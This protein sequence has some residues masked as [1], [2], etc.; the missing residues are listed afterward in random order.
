MNVQY[1]TVTTV[2][3]PLLLLPAL[4]TPRPSKVISHSLYESHLRSAHWI[5]T[6][7]CILSCLKYLRSASNFSNVLVILSI[8]TSCSCCS[9][10]KEKWR[11]QGNQDIFVWITIK[12]FVVFNVF[13]AVAGRYAVIWCNLPTEGA[14]NEIEDVSDTPIRFNIKTNRDLLYTQ[15]FPRLQLVVN[16]FPRL[17]LAAR[18]PALV[19]GCICFPALSTDGMFYRAC[20]W[21]YVSRAFHWRHV[22][23]RLLPATRLIDLYRFLAP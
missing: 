16:V 1:V 18:F 6:S 22:F 10:T 7:R 5:A 19:A 14:S 20:H 12:V 15:L 21:L 9:L 4:T 23:S 11:E 8:K 17:P 3:T 2:P 13:V